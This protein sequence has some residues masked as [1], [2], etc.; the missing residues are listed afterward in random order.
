MNRTAT[1]YTLL[2]GL[3]DLKDVTKFPVGKIWD[4]ELNAADVSQNGDTE[5]I[6]DLQL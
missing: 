3:T 6:V 5:R 2:K 4:C 1:V